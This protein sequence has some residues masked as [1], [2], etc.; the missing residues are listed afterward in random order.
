MILTSFWGNLRNVNREQVVSV[1]RYCRFWNGDSEPNF[2]PSQKL[3]FDFKDGKINEKIYTYH[4]K[5][6]LWDNLNVHEMFKKYDGKIL[7]CYEKTGFCHR[8]ILAEWFKHFGY[9]CRELED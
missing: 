5:W 7:M 8:H 6:Y 9:E 4:F 3:L 1:S 2:F